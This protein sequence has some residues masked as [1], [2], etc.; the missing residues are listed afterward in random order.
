MKAWLRPLLGEVRGTPGAIEL[1]GQT[2]LVLRAS[3][4]EPL[5]PLA[6]PGRVILAQDGGEAPPGLEQA[7]RIS[8]A[9]LARVRG[10]E[11][12]VVHTLG[13]ARARD[14]LAALRLRPARVH[15]VYGPE[16]TLTASASGA[17]GLI[18]SRSLGRR[19]DQIPG[20]AGLASRAGVR[21]DPAWATAASTR[22][23][24]Q[25]GLNHARVQEPG[26][27]PAGRLRI[28]HLIPSLPSGGAERQLTYLAPAQVQAGH[29][30]T[31][32]TT[33]PLEG[34]EAHYAPGLRAA[35]VRV[36]HVPPRP[37]WRPLPDLSLPRKLV[38]DLA[39][40]AA[41]E[42]LLGQVAALRRIAPHVLHCWQDEANAT[43]GLAGLVAD[44]PRVLL[45]TW[46]VNPS[47]FPR[48]HK[49]WFQDSYRL[50]ADSPRVT[51]T[52][53]SRAGGDDY[54]DWSGVPRARYR[55]IPNGFPIDEWPLLS[56]AERTAGRDALGIEADAFV[57][58][59]IFRLAPEK[60]P[61][62]FLEVVRLA[63]ER[64]PGLRALHIGTGGLTPQIRARSRELG[65]AE[66]LTFVGRTEAPREVL[67][68][69]DV[70]LLTSQVEGSPNVSQESQA[71]GLPMLL[72]RVVGSPETILEGESGW[73]FEVGDV[74]G[75]AARI[76]DLAGDRERCQGMGARGRRLVAEEF[77]IDVMLTRTD[78][79]Y[80]R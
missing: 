30:V 70:S 56:P 8:L 47:N 1:E 72:T 58:A 79:A 11:Q 52:A 16:L 65:L 31:V 62:D 22:I 20:L 49:A 73:C 9:E 60:R 10:V 26:P 48:Y 19:L 21:L 64:V 44:V 12:L 53:N 42:D 51:F 37:R 61:Q 5:P 46:N 54:A 2:T 4:D 45:S 63:A 78:A 15:L 57:V 59:G 36:R 55:V 41:G 3:P 32:L 35:G 27:V 38:A 67:G 18:L 74:E 34:A 76:A 69:A 17:A 25:A 13:T 39:A 68:L 24:L 40:H 71:L 43:G 28:V 29:Q 33:Y 23:A 80:R 14:A 75:M 66:V 7:E 50:L 77:S 6:N